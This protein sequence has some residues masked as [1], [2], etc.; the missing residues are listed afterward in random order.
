MDNLKTQVIYRTGRCPHHFG[1]AL[2]CMLSF[3][4]NKLDAMGIGSFKEKS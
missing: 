2:E 3:T 1:F 4:V